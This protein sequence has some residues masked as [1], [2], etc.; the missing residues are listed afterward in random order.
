MSRTN[1]QGQ[2]RRSGRQAAGGSTALTATPGQLVL[3]RER[4]SLESK[5]GMT[6]ARSLSSSRKLLKGRLKRMCKY[7]HCAGGGGRT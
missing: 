3:N 6:K 2:H 4:S 5:P 7:R 1:F